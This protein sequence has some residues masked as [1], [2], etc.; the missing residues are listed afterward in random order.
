MTATWCLREETWLRME[1]STKR[2]LGQEVMQLTELEQVE[3]FSCIQD[4]CF[5][6]FILPLTL[7]LVFS[8]FC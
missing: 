4:V 2:Q 5:M 7:L 6:S 1:L 8:F 3:M